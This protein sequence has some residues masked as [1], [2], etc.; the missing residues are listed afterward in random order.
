MAI[1]Y[2]FGMCKRYT[3]HIPERNF[4]GHF[5]P[6]PF[7]WPMVLHMISWETLTSVFHSAV[8]RRQTKRGLHYQAWRNFAIARI[9]KELN[10][11]INIENYVAS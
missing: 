5:S 1:A 4:L 8:E 6:S 10:N 11:L 7:S 2:G 9:I 3:F